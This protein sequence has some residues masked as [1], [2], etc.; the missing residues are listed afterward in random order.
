M[1]Y[2]IDTQ[3]LIWSLINPEKLSAP[4]QTL[5]KTNSVW[6]SQVSLYEIA[7]K[8]KIGK[9]PEFDLTVEA[10]LSQT[11][12]DGFRLMPIKNTHIAAYD[13]IPL[14]PDHKDPFDRLILATAL[15]ERLPVISAD[16]N[17][18]L[19]VSQIQLIEN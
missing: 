4:N 19:Y 15:S 16:E 18:R 8:Q 3:I 14:F 5:L 12:M 13:H 7:I 2:L 9:L 1:A 17:F 11:R 10:L 6:V